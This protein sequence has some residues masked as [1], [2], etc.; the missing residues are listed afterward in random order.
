MTIDTIP[1]IKQGYQNIL[2]RQVYLV[3]ANFMIGAKNDEIVELV[4]FNCHIWKLSHPTVD[5]KL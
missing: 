3:G 1:L 4:P 2:V 5:I